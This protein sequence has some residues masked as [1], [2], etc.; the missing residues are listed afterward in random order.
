[1]KEM[2]PS[3]VESAAGGGGGISRVVYTRIGLPVV[4][5]RATRKTDRHSEGAGKR[6]RKVR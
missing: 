6:D 5:C 1:M 4:R 2:G 3:T